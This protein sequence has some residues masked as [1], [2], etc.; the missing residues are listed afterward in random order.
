MTSKSKEK[1]RLVE[2]RDYTCLRNGCLVVARRFADLLQPY[3]KEVVPDYLA[4]VDHSLKLEKEEYE[5]LLDKEERRLNELVRELKGEGKSLV[6]VFQGR[7]AAGKSG[8]T[9][10][11][12][13]A[14]DYDM[15]IFQ[16]VHIGP[17]TED[18]K[19]HPFLWRFWQYQRIPEAGQARVFDR[20]WC[21][22]LLVEPV[23]GFVK[24]EEAKQSYQQVR[25]FEWLLNSFGI[26][27]VKC[28]LDITKDEQQNRFDRRKKKKPWKL[29]ESDDVARRHWDD[30]TRAANE[31]FYRTGTDFAPWYLI[32]SED[33]R[34]S[35]VGVLQV[36][37]HV[38]DQQLR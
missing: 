34:Y 31:M 6:V 1:S 36:I 13:E 38:L 32:S 35:R 2:G 25:C 30:Y 24:G 14:L 4:A 9:E 19:A 3:E 15:E 21:E 7:D 12:L 20:S 16:P 22:R 5:P 29:S 28:W 37:N 17:P 11:I 18:E 33:K 23:M 10:R 8:A 27:L 26:I